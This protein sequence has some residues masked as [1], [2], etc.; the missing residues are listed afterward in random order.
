MKSYHIAAYA[1]QAEIDC[2][3]CIA[4]WAE[5]ELRQEGYTISD[6]DKIVYNNPSTV[7]V[8]LFDERSEIL[9]DKLAELWQINLEDEYSYDSGDFPKVA[10]V[11]QIEDVYCG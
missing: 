9:L 2:P 1:F 7:D 6:I 3:D 11:D 4:E 10:F 5:N 8:G